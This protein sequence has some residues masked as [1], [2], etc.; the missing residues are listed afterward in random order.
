[1]S[2]AHYTHTYTYTWHDSFRDISLLQRKTKCL[3]YKT[4]TK[5]NISISH[6]WC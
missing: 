3:F 4:S 2:K 1:M 5:Q 6:Y